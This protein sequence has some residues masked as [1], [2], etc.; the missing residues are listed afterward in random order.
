MGE[1]YLFILESLPVRQE[2][3][4]DHPGDIDNSGSHTG[5]F[6]LICGHWCWQH[7]II[8]PLAYQ[9]LDWEPLTSLQALGRWNAAPSIRQQVHCLK[10]PSG[11][12]QTK[13]WRFL[14]EGLGPGSTPKAL[15]PETPGPTFTHQSHGTS[16]RNSFTQQQA[17]STPQNYQSHAACL[18][19]TQ[20]TQSRLA[21]APGPP[22]I[23]P[24]PSA[25]WHCH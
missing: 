2:A 15:Q 4:G 13:T 10:T 24:H 17:N 1:T 18:V 9:H 21:P 3:T 7:F 14:P 12:S 6:T 5:E 16:P 23:Q 11:G 20:K 25:V 19:R 22:L 8:R